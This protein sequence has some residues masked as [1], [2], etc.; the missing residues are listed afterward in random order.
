MLVWGDQV[1][2]ES[3]R[4]KLGQLGAALRR[5]GRMPAGIERHAALVAALVEAGELAQGLADA[6]VRGGW[7]R[8]PLE[9]PT[10]PRW[11]CSRGSPARCARPG[12]A[13]SPGSTRSPEDGAPGARGGAASRRGAHQAR[14]GLR[15]LL[16]LPGELPRG[17]HGGVA[18]AG[19][20]IRV[21]GIRSIGAPLAALVA[22]ALGAPPPV[23][24]RPVG[25]PPHRRVA[26]AEE[27]AAELLADASSARFAVVDEG[28]GLSGSSFGAVADFLEDQGVAPGR[29]HFFASHR[30]PL[31]PCA[32][33]R[34][35]RRW[36]RAT[37]PRGG[38][39]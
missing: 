9:Q 38:P 13:A 1:R 33:S 29:I 8:R 3:P 11:P 14:G 37:P 36:A 6:A 19:Q 5:L 2:L 23:T 12:K 20:P 24:L 15:P 10:P 39:R 7:A 18:A 28:P 30:G 4:E 25:D 31:A 34:H 32:S 22:V 26:I 27:L 35:R 21:V 17:R 16:A